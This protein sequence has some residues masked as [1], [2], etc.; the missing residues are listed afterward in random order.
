MNLTSD[1]RGRNI[2][3]QTRNKSGERKYSEHY[4]MS[5]IYIARTGELTICVQW[6]ST[7]ILYGPQYP[8]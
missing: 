2:I 7:F 5:S 4:K 3:F 1:N 6:S 8:Q